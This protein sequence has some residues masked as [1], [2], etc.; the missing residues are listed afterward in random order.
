MSSSRSFSAVRVVRRLLVALFVTPFA[1]AIGLTLV[2]RYRR[3]GKNN[4]PFPRSVPTEVEVEDG[5][6]TVTGSSVALQTVLTALSGEGITAERLR[7]T[8][9]TLDDAY[10]RATR[11]VRHG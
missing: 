9:P 6:V 7:V 11:E 5:T 8:T 4:S 1:L 3:E 2:D 10:L